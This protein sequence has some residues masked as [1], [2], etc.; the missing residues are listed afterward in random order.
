MELSELIWF[1][2]W[3]FI[4]SNSLILGLLFITVKSKNKRANIYLGFFLWSIV[5]QIF[6]DF[7]S[8]FS[9]E[10]EFGYSLFVIEPFLFGLPLLFFYLLATI[11]KEIKK[12]HYLLFLPGIFHNVLL[13]TEG[14]FLEESS[15]TIYEA[16]VYLLEIILIVYA[17][18]VLQ[19]HCNSIVNFYSNLE[20]KTLT[21]LKRIF[22]LNILIHF[23]NISTFIFDLSNIEIIEL[24]ID[25]SAL[26]LTVFMIF[27]IAYNG[28]S[29]PEIFSQ[30]HFLRN[31]ENMSVERSNPNEVQKNN[32]EEDTIKFNKIKT[33]IQK[34]E[35][36]IDPKLNLNSLSEALDLKEKELSRLIKECSDVNF[37]QF[38]NSFRVEKFKKLLA[39]KR[40]Q[41]LSLLGLAN[42]AGFPSKSTFY[43]VFKAFE[44][45]TPKQYQESL[46]KSK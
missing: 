6:N 8:E 41:Q 34:E 9:I 40:A 18:I 3:L 28:F 38:V 19:N 21:W 22:A 14:F 35:L 32:S 39:S 11:N 10:E 27:W 7:L 43:S 30:R 46:N 13:Y 31:D 15:I 42:E 2:P 24:S 29:Q 45:M 16:N 25:L 37:Y 17:Y 20:N 4:F 26:G 12:W 33:Q 36:F 5:V 23:L 44:G 1:L